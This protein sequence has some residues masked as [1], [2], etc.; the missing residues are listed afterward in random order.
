M[1]QISET[2]ESRPSE[3]AGKR[4]PGGGGGIPWGK[5]S[6]QLRSDQ[7]QRAPDLE[8]TFGD[9]GVRSRELAMEHWSKRPKA[10]KWRAEGKEGVEQ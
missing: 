4:C 5:D 8:K 10:A 7:K 3:E 2:L 6:T 1:A 9:G